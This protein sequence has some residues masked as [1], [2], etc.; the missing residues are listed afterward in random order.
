ME[1]QSTSKFLSYVLRHHP[2]EIGITLDSAGWVP[3][4]ELLSA[5]RKHGRGIS[6]SLLREIVAASDKQRFAISD[7]GLKMRASQGHSVPVEL[8]YEPAE[9]PTVLYHGTVDRAVESIRATGL[10]KG[11][12]HHVHLS[13]DVKTAGAV[14]GRRGRA[15]ILTVDAARMRRAGCLFYRSANGVW[16]TDHVPAA[17]ITFDEG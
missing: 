16:L 4:A 15:V 11:Q 3:V 1:H 10:V 12:R 2:A 9:P 13:A 8:G 14:G 6:E 7:D 17:F 5:M